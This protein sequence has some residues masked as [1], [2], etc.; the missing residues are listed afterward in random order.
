MIIILGPRDGQIAGMPG[1]C[2]ALAGAT[3][4]PTKVGVDAASP[5]HLLV[6]TSFEPLNEISQTVFH[7]S[8]RKVRLLLLIQ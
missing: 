5:A 7:V 2:G 8:N 3:A 1:I 4:F 6:R